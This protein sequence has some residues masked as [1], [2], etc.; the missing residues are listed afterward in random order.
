MSLLQIPEMKNISS[1][2]P[3]G[4]QAVSI[5][6]AGIITGAVIM[7]SIALYEDDLSSLFS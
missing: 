1:E 7:L 4:F 3:Q 2:D 5:Q 6:L